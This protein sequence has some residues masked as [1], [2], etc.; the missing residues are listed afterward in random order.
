MQDF[1]N[2][3]TKAAPDPGL[4]DRLLDRG[5]IAKAMR[6]ARAQGVAIPQARIDEVA[7]QMLK[8]HRASEL[9]S[10]IGYTD[11][12]LPFDATTLLEAAFDARDYHGFLKHAHRLK[13]SGVQ[14]HVAEAIAA[15]R[16]A[17]PAEADAWSRK[18]AQR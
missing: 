12:R 3:V 14:A 10:L 16:E 17:A 1:R 9:M 4:I 6:Q 8:R 5:H 2:R 7:S 11:V 13:V 18:F 15:L